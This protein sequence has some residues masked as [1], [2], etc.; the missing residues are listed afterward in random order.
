M[1]GRG[2]G[3]GEGGSRRGQRVGRI[4][5]ALELTT[6]RIGATGGQGS[7][8]SSGGISGEWTSGA[9]VWSSGG[10]RVCSDRLG[11]HA[12]WPDHVVEAVMAGSGGRCEDALEEEVCEASDAGERV[13]AAEGGVRL[14]EG[15]ERAGARLQSD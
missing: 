2:D 7:G 5:R 11:S 4:S 10:R 3:N 9:V 15:G 8:T 14:G 13:V 1:L 12:G 6:G